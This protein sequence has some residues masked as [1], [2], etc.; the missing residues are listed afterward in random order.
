MWLA[1]VP[2]AM[3][4]RMWPPPAPRSLALRRKLC[5]GRNF[6]HIAVVRGPRRFVVDEHAGAAA[7]RPRFECDGAKVGNI[8]SADDVETFVAHPAQVRRFL[9]SGEF[10]CQFLRNGG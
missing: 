9:L 4:K 2:L 5:A 8:M 10:V 1:M 7:P 3:L 6:A